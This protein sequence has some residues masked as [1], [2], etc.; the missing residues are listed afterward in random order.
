MTTLERIIEET[1]TLKL[2]ELEL[3]RAV[4]EELLSADIKPPITEDEFE[5]YLAAKGI[6]ALP[7]P[8]PEDYDF[9]RW[10][11]IKVKG[12]PLSEMIIEER[13]WKIWMLRG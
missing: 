7:E 11:P 8:L 2:H 13:R 6:I 1:R 12:K 4:I 3:L 5:R 10:E 9:D